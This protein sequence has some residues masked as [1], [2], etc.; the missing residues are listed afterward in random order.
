MVSTWSERVELSALCIFGCI[1][2]QSMAAEHSGNVKQEKD[3]T[4]KGSDR[5]TFLASKREVKRHGHHAR[6]NNL[7]LSTALTNT[8]PMHKVKPIPS[9]RLG[10]AMWHEHVA[11]DKACRGSE[12]RQISREKTKKQGAASMRLTA[13][14]KE[15]DML[16]TPSLKFKRSRHIDIPVLNSQASATLDEPQQARTNGQLRPRVHA[17][18]YTGVGCVY[19]EKRFRQAKRRHVTTL[20][21][22]SSIVP[23]IGA[24]QALSNDSLRSQ[25]RS[26]LR[27]CSHTER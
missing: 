9:E 8:Q 19:T 16:R 21:N 10:T 12:L 11:P 14:A 4:S 15:G 5:V 26:Q 23:Q 2:S 3:R 20:N 13:P 24:L 27:S 1:P 17:R 25:R 6:R 22:E 18:V 7:L